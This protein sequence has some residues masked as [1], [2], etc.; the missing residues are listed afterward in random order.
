MNGK[1]HITGPHYQKQ[2]RPAVNFYAVDARRGAEDNVNVS[3]QHSSA[4]HFATVVDSVVRTKCCTS[5]MVTYLIYGIILLIAG[6]K[7]YH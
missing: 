7:V 2:P 5:L 3:R 1:L 6:L 4:L